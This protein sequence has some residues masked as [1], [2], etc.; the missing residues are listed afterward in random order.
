[1]ENDINNLCFRCVHYYNYISIPRW[2]EMEKLNEYRTSEIPKRF[3]F[4]Y[5]KKKKINKKLL[6]IKY[7][8][9]R[10][11][12][13]FSIIYGERVVGFIQYIETA[14]ADDS[15]TRP[16]TRHRRRCSSHTRYERMRFLAFIYLYYIL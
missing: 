3:T 15:Y 12:F 5:E 14:V 10:Y 13:V 9:K 8:N 6:W 11:I 7:K 2:M 16:S 1:M 4:F